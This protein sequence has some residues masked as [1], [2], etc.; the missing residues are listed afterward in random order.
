[1]TAVSSSRSCS[2]G[3]NA[4]SP[5]LTN[6]RSLSAFNQIHIDNQLHSTNYTIPVGCISPIWGDIL[7]TTPFSL[8]FD[9][10][11]GVVEFFRLIMFGGVGRSRGGRLGWKP[12]TCGEL[13]ESLYLTLPGL[14]VFEK[15]S[16]KPY[17]LYL[18]RTLRGR[19]YTY[20]KKPF[21]EEKG[22]LLEDC[23][24]TSRLY[25]IFPKLFF[26]R[27]KN[28]LCFIIRSF[29]YLQFKVVSNLIH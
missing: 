7:P 14:T 1:M 23:L 20:L 9:L 22:L 8:D 11:E 26:L 10:V 16:T 5:L 19:K 13:I 21:H 6:K 29:R 27:R 3:V 15:F 18:G 17:T 12:K 28:V 2:T 24:S 4:S 25:V